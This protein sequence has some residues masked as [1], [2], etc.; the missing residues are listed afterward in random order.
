MSR[1]QGGGH[2]WERGEGRGARGPSHVEPGTRHGIPDQAKIK[3]M[4]GEGGSMTS[5]TQTKAGWPSSASGE[6]VR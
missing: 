3:C 6:G 5:V 4:G 1:I 2:V